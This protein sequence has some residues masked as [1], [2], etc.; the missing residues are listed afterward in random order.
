MVYE[1]SLLLFNYEV[2]YWISGWVSFF[3]IIVM[4]VFS[5]LCDDIYAYLLMFVESR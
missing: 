3:G 5:F 1:T 2:I 4:V